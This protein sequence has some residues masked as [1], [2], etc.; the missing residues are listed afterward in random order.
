MAKS[1]CETCANMRKR[2]WENE[3]NPDTTFF[4]IRCNSFSPWNVTFHVVTE[5]NQYEEKKLTR[6]EYESEVPK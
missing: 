6:K 4:E 1:L 3:K 5:C 2:R